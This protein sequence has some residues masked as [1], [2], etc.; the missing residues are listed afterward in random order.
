MKAMSMLT[1]VRKKTREITLRELILGGFLAIWNTVRQCAAYLEQNAR[2]QNTGAA[3]VSLL[4][5][6]ER[7]AERGTCKAHGSTLVKKLLKPWSANCGLMQNL[8][9]TVLVWYV[10]C[11]AFSFAL[12]DLTR[13][14]FD[15]APSYIRS[16]T[17]EPQR[18]RQFSFLG[19]FG[20]WGRMENFW[21]DQISAK[22]C[23]F[24]GWFFQLFDYKIYRQSTK[25]CFLASACKSY[26]M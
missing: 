7:N 5:W 24:F 6:E 2:T 9:S 16:D 26:I 25:Q 15:S 8:R 17:I 19:R 11:S 13:I 18:Y 10:L 21:N 1:L 3:S 23:Y 12:W 22:V 4:C 20:L 14:C